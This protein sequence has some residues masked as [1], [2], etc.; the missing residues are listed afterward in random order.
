MTRNV[1]SHLRANGVYGFG[2][3]VMFDGVEGFV[4]QVMAN[5]V[6]GSVSEVVANGVMDNGV[7]SNGVSESVP[8][9]VANGVKANGVSGSALEV[10]ANGVMVYETMSNDVN[11]SVQEV[12]DN[13][14]M[15][16]GVGGSAS[17]VV[18]SVNGLGSQVEANGVIDNGFSGS[19]NRVGSNGVGELVSQFVAGVRSSSVR[20]VAAQSAPQV[21]KDR[22]LRYFNKEVHEDLARLR[23]YR[24][25]ANGLRVVVR[26]RRHRITQLESLRNYREARDT[27]NFWERMQLEDVEK[28]TRALLMMRETESKI[29]EKARFILNL[30]DVV[31]E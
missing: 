15:V 9:V 31:V 1:A 27:I 20:G 21:D 28:G 24:S 26:R 3:C 16:N 7:M 25:I 6:R 17:Q 14:V 5:S 2:P 12:L 8:E 23:E 13:D 11:E 30:R 4:P 10:A 29:G 18:S 22:L 19:A